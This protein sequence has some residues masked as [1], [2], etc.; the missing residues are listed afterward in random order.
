M[1]YDVVIVGS[2]FGGICSA[3]K[4]REAGIDNFVMLE[5]DEVFGGTWRVNTYPGAAC[6]IPSHLYSFSFAQNA[7][8]SRL[9]PRQ[10]ELLEYTQ[11]VV[12]DFDLERHLRLGTALRSAQFDEATGRWHLATSKG[13]MTARAVIFAI[14][15]LGRPS[16]PQFPGAQRF[17]GQSFHSAQWDHSIDLGGKRVAVI[18]S[19]ASAVQFVPEIQP[20]VQQLDHYQRTAH[21]VLPRPDRTVTRVEQWLLDRARPLQL[22][23]RAKHYMQFESRVVLF[24]F[25]P[26]LAKL[27]QW[28]AMRHLKRQV[29]DPQ[30]R[31][32]LV[33]DYTLGCKRVL[34]TN[35]Y[36]PALSQS[37]VAVL[38]D[39]IHEV[40]EHSIVTGSGEERPVD[41]I[42]Y[43]TG[44]DV[45][46]AYGPIELRGRDGCSFAQALEDGAG[47]YKGATVAGFPNFF[48]ITGPNTLLGHNSM[49]YMIESSVR[50]AVDGVRRVLRG[51]LHS[52]EV[53]PAVQGAYN[54]KLQQKLKGTVWHTGCKSW[55][56]DSRGRNLVIWP[57]FTFHFRHITR[58]FDIDSYIVR[59]SA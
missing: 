7:H 47:A 24:I 41:V 11:R 22:L 10:D 46:H 38:K 36:Y 3:I 26:V 48:M 54:R 31:A 51:G 40:R 49:I 23:Y 59:R 18:G 1:D 8:W 45:E 5:K 13:E 35:D 17:R 9:F 15:L 44:F 55:Y 12:R 19:G 20:L 53:Q 37:N 30:L 6:D 56:L 42:I 58:R 50:Y 21:W 33:P 29:A 34:L 25:L 52:V 27:M 32:R 2:G 4:L 14:G 43:A 16:I 28:Q 39:G 57:G